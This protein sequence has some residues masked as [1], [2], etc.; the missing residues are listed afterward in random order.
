M[1]GYDREAFLYS[2]GNVR[3]TLDRHL[4]TGL[5]PEDFW[6]PER[7]ALSPLRGTTVLEVKYDAFLPDVVRLAV[8]VPDRRAEAC[9]KYA[10]CRRFD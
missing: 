10:L 7:L 2:P 4:R 3:V 6:R 8:Q 9:S 1:V 5:G